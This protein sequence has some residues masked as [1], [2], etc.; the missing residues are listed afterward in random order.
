MNAWDAFRHRDDESF[1]AP[2]RD[3]Q[4]EKP[5]QSGEQHTFREELPNDPRPACPQSAAE[6]HFLSANRST[7]EKKVR[8]VSI[9]DEQNTND[10]A[11][12]DIES[13]ADVADQFVTQRND[14]HA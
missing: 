9:G 5:T 6:S 11:E 7:G 13:G 1:S 12:K 14:C 2:L 10:G 4:A 3:E 8:D